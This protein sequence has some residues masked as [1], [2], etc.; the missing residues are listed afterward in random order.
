MI[1][2]Q[3]FTDD[4]ESYIRPSTFPV[5]IKLATASEQIPEK[6]KIPTRDLKVRVA[7][8]QTISIARRYGWSLAISADEI[9]CPLTK[10]AFG[11][12]PVTE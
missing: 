9:S 12:K 8:C 6:M 2:L 4:L 1:E 11:F 3:K 7:T 5:A 10:V